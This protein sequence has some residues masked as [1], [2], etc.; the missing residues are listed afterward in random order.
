[1]D[2]ECDDEDVDQQE[3]DE[4]ATHDECAVDTVVDPERT[5]V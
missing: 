3:D 5:G 1:M 4:G 2:Q